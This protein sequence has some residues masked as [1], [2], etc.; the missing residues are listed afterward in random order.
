MSRIFSQIRTKWLP[1]TDIVAVSISALNRPVQSDCCEY[2]TLNWK[3]KCVIVLFAFNLFEAASPDPCLVVSRT[4]DQDEW[5]RHENSKPFCEPS[6]PTKW[7]L[8]LQRIRFK[9]WHSAYLKWCSDSIPKSFGNSQTLFVMDMRVNMLLCKRPKICV[10]SIFNNEQSRS[11]SFWVKSRS[12]FPTEFGANQRG[13]QK[14]KIDAPQKS[15]KA[16]LWPRWQCTY[17]FWVLRRRRRRGFEC[18]FPRIWVKRI[19]AI[20]ESFDSLNSSSLEFVDTEHD[21]ISLISPPLV[22]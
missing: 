11:R 12:R 4:I 18:E 19:R 21:A 20:D 13:F 8:S 7:F 22:L 5:R 6:Y 10:S 17:H 16:F 1:F 2:F 14:P 3:L 15:P 9:L